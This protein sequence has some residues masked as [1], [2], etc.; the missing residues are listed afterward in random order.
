MWV[1]AFSIHFA[2]ISALRKSLKIAFY[3]IEACIGVV[4]SIKVIVMLCV[5]FRDFFKVL[6]IVLP[7]FSPSSKDI[8]CFLAKD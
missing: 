8:L 4:D 7:Y 1:L 5:N 6:M 2:F 3:I